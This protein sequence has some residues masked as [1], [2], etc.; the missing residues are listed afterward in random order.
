MSN[1]NEYF[2]EVVLKFGQE[3]HKISIRFVVYGVIPPFHDD[4]FNSLRQNSVFSRP[5]SDKISGTIADQSKYIDKNKSST[6][7]IRNNLKWRAAAGYSQ[8]VRT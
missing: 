3:I 5:S 6:F 4:V 2:D 7:S 8:Q 1:Q